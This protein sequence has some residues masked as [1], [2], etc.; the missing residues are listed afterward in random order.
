MERYLWI[1][2]SE[3][4][5]YCPLEVIYKP[6]EALREDFWRRILACEELEIEELAGSVYV[7]LADSEAVHSKDMNYKASRLLR[8]LAS[9]EAA[10]A[11]GYYG[12]IVVARRRMDEAGKSFI[13][14]LDE[15][16]VERLKKG[17]LGA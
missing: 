15:E 2:T 7:A 1:P 14:L 6:E 12:P 10:Q 8:G 5:E 17:Q 3:A 9:A 16:D 13:G 4:G 11:E